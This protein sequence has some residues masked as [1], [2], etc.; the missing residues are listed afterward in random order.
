L[1]RKPACRATLCSGHA[2]LSQRW[3]AS[4]K[5]DVTSATCSSNGL[6]LSVWKCLALDRSDPYWS[7]AAFRTSALQT[8]LQLCRGQLEALQASAQES[9]PA[10][11]APLCRAL[12]L[13]TEHG[14]VAPTLRRRCKELL[15]DVDQAAAEAVASRRPLVNSAL[16]RKA[17]RKLYNPKFEMGYDKR[18]D[19]DPD[20]ERSEFKQYKRM[21]SKEQRGAL[22]CHRCQRLKQRACAAAHL[23]AG[24]VH[25]LTIALLPASCPRKA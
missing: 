6:P 10:A 25:V 9:L 23:A 18:R 12:Q 21:A 19:Y 22:L 11:M 16:M 17:P 1:L 3:L 14:A 8:V 4:A 7:S 5:P 20:R 13:L 2:Q 15:A 24:S